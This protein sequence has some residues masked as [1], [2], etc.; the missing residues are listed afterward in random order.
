MCRYSLNES[1]AD[2]QFENRPGELRPERPRLRDPRV[3]DDPTN[4]IGV[5]PAKGGCRQ[6]RS[7]SLAEALFI[8]P[9]RRPA[10]NEKGM[11][12]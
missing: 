9:R 6:K 8:L 7:A 10:R 4:L 5:M 12:R 11:T 2:V 1:I 3:A